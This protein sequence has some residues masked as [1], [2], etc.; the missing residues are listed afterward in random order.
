MI[1]HYPAPVLAHPPSDIFHQPFLDNL[2][3]IKKKKIFSKTL[4]PELDLCVSST[5]QTNPIP[6]R[7]EL[8]SPGTGELGNYSAGV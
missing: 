4:A 6:G 5:F 3:L 7:K 8:G 2:P 1:E